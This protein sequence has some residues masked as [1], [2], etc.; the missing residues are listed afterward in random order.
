MKV[1]KNVGWKKKRRGYG[2]DCRPVGK[3]EG[4]SHWICW[5]VMNSELNISN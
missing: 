5:H 2:T 1:Q 4:R 3:A